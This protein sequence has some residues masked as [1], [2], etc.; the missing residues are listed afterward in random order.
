M[1]IQDS[2]DRVGTEVSQ[3]DLARELDDHAFAQIE[4]AFYERSVLCFRDQVLD[5]ETLISN[6][7]VA[8]HEPQALN[9]L[10]C[11]LVVP[12]D[13]I[14]D[15]EQVTSITQQPP[16]LV[17]HRVELTLRKGFEALD[18]PIR[19]RVEVGQFTPFPVDLEMSLAE[20]AHEDLA[21]G[22]V[23]LEAP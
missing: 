11:T 17:S 1:Q 10:S 21:L 19:F 14:E 22:R 15:L 7:P 12:Y 23:P 4:S 13:V 8:Q 20:F 2:D 9:H 16:D 18:D 6:V 5:L 3:F